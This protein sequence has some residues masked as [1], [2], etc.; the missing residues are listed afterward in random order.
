MA[1]T[2][3]SEIRV[4]GELIN[5][6][7]AYSHP[8]SA[9]VYELL[10]REKDYKA[11]VEW[12]KSIIDEVGLSESRSLLDVGCGT[13]LHLMYLQ[14]YFPE[15][16]GLDLSTSQIAKAKT[17]LSNVKLTTGDMEEFDLGRQF[18]VVTNLYG[19]IGNLYSRPMID[20]GV[21]S[22]V[23][24]TTPGGLIVIQPWD[25][26][27]TFNYHKPLRFDTMSSS[28][29][30]QHISRMSTFI[31]QPLEGEEGR[32]D[33]TCSYTYGRTAGNKTVIDFFV[34]RQS[35]GIYRPETYAEVLQKAGATNVWIKDPPPHLSSRVKPLVVA[36]M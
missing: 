34:D 13:G 29:G 2:P 6:S 26:P 25:T 27:D 4:N 14:R 33:T 20:R 16:A 17:R 10:Y 15:I 30:T 18:A 23:R 36:R 28:D 21:R 8:L 7:P 12:I 35:L 1:R 31:S 3:E 24:H 11:E 19:A 22:M 5:P 32:L 9:D